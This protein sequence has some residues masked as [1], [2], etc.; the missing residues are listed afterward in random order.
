MR[1][2]LIQFTSSDNPADNR[3]RLLPMV[4]AAKAGGADLV[5]TPEVVNCVSTSRARQAEV[6][7]GEGEDPVLAGLRDAAARHG[8]WLLAGSL[9]LKGEAADDPRLVN[10]SIL[11][12]AAGA[13]A[14]R[15]DKIHL[16]DVAVTAAETYRESAA[17]RPG[18]RAV[19]ADTP[20]GRIGLTICYDLRF[21]G[22]YRRLAQAGAW[23]MTVPA[24]FSTATGP[25]HWEVLLRARAI[26]CGAYVLAPAQTGDH[27]RREGRARASYGHSLAVGPWGEVLADAG[28]APGLTLVDLDPAA[29]RAARARI[30]ALG[31]D[32]PF[33][34]PEAG[35]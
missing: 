8:V 31:H 1:A 3:A 21:P 17:F 10:R 34:A 2:A 30:P 7:T 4:A 11:I 16:F 14:A 24:A 25:A 35:P 13:I 27:P 6:L 19:A 9:A 28:T 29:A 23:V 33:A 20:W 5:L 32:R 15:Y 12:D 22:L 26:E 18:D